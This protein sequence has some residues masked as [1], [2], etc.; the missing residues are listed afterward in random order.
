MRRSFPQPTT[1]EETGLELSLLVDMMLKTIYFLGRPSGR[2]LSEQLAF[3]F[4]VLEE[5]ITFL[6]QEQVIEIVGSSGVGEQAYQYA[7]TDRGRHKA[8]EALARS[9]T[10]ARRRCRSICTSRYCRANRRATFA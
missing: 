8:E 3:S 4:A 7:L 10:S 9:P 2:A 1:V 6:R 5:L